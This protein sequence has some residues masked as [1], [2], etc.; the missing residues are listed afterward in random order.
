MIL[1]YW[2]G[3]KVI[4]FS[5]SRFQ[6]QAYI[7]RTLAERNKDERLKKKRILTSTVSQVVSKD[8]KEKMVDQ[9]TKVIRTASQQQVRQSCD[10]EDE[11]QDDYFDE[12]MEEEASPEN[13][14][15]LLR[16]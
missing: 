12:E 4:N 15:N 11:D 5:Y 2:V 8:K 7:Q 1:V 6:R 16:L 10:D 9:S 3:L 13:I 14:V